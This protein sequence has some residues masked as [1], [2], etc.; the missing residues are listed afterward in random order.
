MPKKKEAK[1]NAR[2]EAIEQY[3]QNHQRVSLEDLDQKGLVL[4]A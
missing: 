2:I 4:P 1:K 3:I